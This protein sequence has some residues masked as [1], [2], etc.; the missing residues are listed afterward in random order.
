M[1]EHLESADT[2]HLQ[3]KA[4]VGTRCSKID[5]YW[6]PYQADVM[7]RSEEA[8]YCS[9][10]LVDAIKLVFSKFNRDLLVS[11][12]FW[13]CVAVS[14]CK[15]GFFLFK[16][17]S[18]DDKNQVSIDG[19]A[20][21]F[22]CNNVKRV[23]QTIVKGLPNRDKTKYQLYGLTVKPIDA[24]GVTNIKVEAES[25]KSDE[26]KAEAEPPAKKQRLKEDSKSFFSQLFKF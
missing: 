4:N 26:E 19:V 17:H 25:D 14:H 9:V 21:S 1:M 8:S 7:L 6:L 12:G 15:P 3:G 13:F 10:P 23:V 18:V 20:R 24:A 2:E 16:S 5:L 22:W 11:D